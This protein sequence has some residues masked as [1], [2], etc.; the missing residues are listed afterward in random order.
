V[1][2]PVPNTKSAAWDL[3]GSLFWES[4]R[5]TAKPNAAEVALFGAGIGAGTR[6]SVV[7]ASTKALVEALLETGA[8]VTVLDFSERM[9]A[10]L[11]SVLP[12]GSCRILSHDI[13]GPAP[14]G[15]GG[16]QQFV[17]ND[18]LV[19]RFSDTEAQRGISGMLELLAPG[20]VLRTSVK[21]GLYPMDERMIEIGRARGWLD[22][23]YDAGKHVIDYAAAGDVLPA[24]LLAHGEIDRELLLRWYQG[25]GREQ[26]FEHEDVLA[27]I[28]GAVAGRRRL[29]LR[30][31]LLFGGAPA[32][33]LYEAGAYEAEAYEPEAYEPVGR[34]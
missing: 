12:A 26:R 30:G 13:T 20:G 14:D 16:T 31:S 25:R 32:T 21:L 6:V 3:I 29:R 33:R 5:T 11:R 17:L 9:C 19:N 7:G 24:A 1:S 23:F 28:T 15:L 22:R 10:D 34:G 4:G 18:R 2:A 8:E 27:L